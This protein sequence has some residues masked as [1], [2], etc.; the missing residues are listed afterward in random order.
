MLMLRLFIILFCLC[1]VTLANPPSAQA[2]LF[3]LLF[4]RSSTRPMCRQIPSSEYNPD[5]YSQVADQEQDCSNYGFGLFASDLLPYTSV[6]CGNPVDVI[7]SFFGDTLNDSHIVN[8]ERNSALTTQAI[9]SLSQSTESRSQAPAWKRMV[10][11]LGSLFTNIK[12]A[13]GETLRY[14]NTGLNLRLRPQA[15]QIRDR[16]TYCQFLLECQQNN[17]ADRQHLTAGGIPL[18]RC[19][20]PM[21]YDIYPQ[22]P[23]RTELALESEVCQEAVSK[24]SSYDDPYQFFTLEN[25]AQEKDFITKFLALDPTYKARDLIVVCT[26]KA[27]RTEANEIARKFYSSRSFECQEI[28]IPPGLVAACQGI[29]NQLGAITPIDKTTEL[30]AEMSAIRAN[31]ETQRAR[32]VSLNLSTQTLSLLG[33]DSAQRRERYAMRI[34]AEFDQTNACTTTITNDEQYGE[35]NTEILASDSMNVPTNANITRINEEGTSYLAKR[36]FTI[37]PVGFDICFNELLRQN[38]N[39]ATK[40]MTSATFFASSAAGQD[41]DL[42]PHPYSL[43][44]DNCSAQASEYERDAQGN[45]LRDADGNPLRLL[46]RFF[47]LAYSP[48]AESSVF[49]KGAGASLF[50]LI[51]LKSA[52]TSASDPSSASDR[53]CGWEEY[54]LGLPPPPGCNVASGQ[55]A[56]GPVAQHLFLPSCNGQICYDHI[57]QA[58]NSASCNG[59]VV[60]PLIAIAIALNENGGLVSCNQNAIEPNHFGC[61]LRSPGTIEEKL[62]C[63]LRTLTSNCSQSSVQILKRYGYCCNYGD[64][65]CTGIYQEL[66]YCDAAGQRCTPL[67]DQICQDLNY[68]IAPLQVLMG[69]T[70]ITN[71]NLFVSSGDAASYANSLSQYLSAS[72]STWEAYYQGYIESYTQQNNCPQ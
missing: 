8:I 37:A 34:N 42:M 16:Y 47:N 67:P 41:R 30:E 5:A 56:S 58:A 11:E 14:V 26:D 71:T 36:T 19:T 40:A 50:A 51:G 63:M 27:P 53:T 20:N 32:V 12:A 68:R 64:G 35:A 4:G 29:W 72:Q 43:D 9:T 15:L 57:M 45:V 28:I 46:R 60:N 3:S 38:Q 33:L 48:N 22:D 39:S 1:G 59:M 21:P 62:D 17:Q 23:N 70:G 54:K 7:F 44:C 69:N 49:T 31:P 2:D 13:G 55:I 24:M 66:N 61:N 6:T 10:E 18:K 65:S 25:W 52:Y